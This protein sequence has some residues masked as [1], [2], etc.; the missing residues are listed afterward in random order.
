MKI[1]RRNLLKSAYCLFIIAADIF[2]ALFL[3]YIAITMPEKLSSLTILQSILVIA[4]V[5]FM[6]VPL[7]HYIILDVNEI[8]IPNLIL[9]SQIKTYQYNEIDEIIFTYYKLEGV[10]MRIK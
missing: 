10:A 2:V 8:K 3:I 9:K 7:L 4:G 5:N 6:A 1:Y